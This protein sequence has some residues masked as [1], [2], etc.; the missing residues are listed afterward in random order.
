[1]LGAGIVIGGISL[2]FREQLGFHVPFIFLLAVFLAAL[3]ASLS[4]IVV[5]YFPKSH[6]LS[7]NTVAMA[8]GAVTLLIVSLFAHETF[9]LPSL[10]ST[11]L[12]LGWLI[13]SSTI[14][15]VLM[16]WMLSH[17]SASKTSYTS[18]LS[19]LVTVAA[20]SFLTGETVTPAFLLG[21]T[22][23]ILGVYIGALTE[24]GT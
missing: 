9:R 2:V 5:K 22:L 21:A 10:P 17:W 23:V 8:V 3:S 19:P 20:S 15:F 1:M 7:T 14:A 11:W 12:A 24:Q 16:V 6:P 4:G 13:V 18:V